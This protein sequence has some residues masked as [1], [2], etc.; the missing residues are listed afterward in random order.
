MDP[1]PEERMR[2]IAREEIAIAERITLL[3]IAVRELRDEV[4]EYRRDH[5]TFEAAMMNQF[6]AMGSRFD[7]LERDVKDGFKAV[8]DR[9]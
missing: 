2:E 6:E 3:E 9:L 1:A 5:K 7:R 8:L 4:R